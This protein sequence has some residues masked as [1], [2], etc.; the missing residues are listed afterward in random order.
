[1]KRVLIVGANSYIGKSFRSWI[2]EN[3]ISEMGLDSLSLRDDTWKNIDLHEYD[4]V[5][6]LAAI[7]HSPKAEASLYYKVNRD[8]AVEFAKKAKNEGVKH[9]IFIS[10]LSV[11]GDEVNDVIDQH[12]I[13]KPSNHYGKSKWE[14][15]NEILRLESDEFHVSIVRPPLV[16]GPQAPGNFARI[17]NF[18]MLMPVVPFISN[19]RSMIFIDNLSNFLFILIKNEVKGIFIPQ[20]ANSVCT[21][22]ILLESRAISGKKTLVL[23]IKLP[24][25]LK[26]KTKIVDKVFGDLLVDP[27]LS[28]INEQYSRVTFKESIFLSVTKQ[29]KDVDGTCSSE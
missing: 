23:P 27:Q 26:K 24:Q 16:Y 7:V 22:E 18:S 1:M 12:T 2:A 15:E 11:Y 9:F 19:K 3:S 14:A 29:D 21:S 20:N 4:S 13:P 17:M 6:H 28:S 5:L 8:L 25:K 10:T